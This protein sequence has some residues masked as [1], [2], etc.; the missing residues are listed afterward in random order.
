MIGADAALERPGAELQAIVARNPGG[1]STIPASVA[2]RLVEALGLASSDE[3]ALLALP[4]AE[5]MARPAISRLSRRGR[6]HRGGDPATSLLGANLEF[7]GSELTTTIHAEGFVALRARNRGRCPR[8]ARGA[9]RRIRVPTAGRRSRNPQSA[10]GLAPRRPRGEPANAPRTCIRGPFDPMPWASRATRLADAAWPAL[11]FRGALPRRRRLLLG[12]ARGRRARPR[13]LLQGAQR[14][15]PADVQ[16]VRLHAAGC[17]ESVAVQPVDQRASGGAHRDRR[18][19]ARTHADDQRG[20]AGAHRMAA[21]SIPE[22]GF[23][24]LLGAVAPD[25]AVNVVRWGHVVSGNGDMVDRTNWWLALPPSAVAN[26]AETWIPVGLPGF[27]GEEK[28]RRQA[29][30]D[31]RF[32]A[33]GWRLGHFVHGRIVSPAEAI[34]EYEASYRAFLHANPRARRLPHRAVRQRLRQRR[35]ERARR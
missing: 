10:D 11:A 19:R 25:A 26:L 3:L 24:A 2:A 6:R 29:L 5:A 33:D 13:A 31:E 21:P 35:G 34:A 8:N 27:T 23:R 12:T 7:P 30:F 14:G 15:R 32:G 17:V 18:C 20:L 4:L 1:A 16:R 28:A 22:P 9:R